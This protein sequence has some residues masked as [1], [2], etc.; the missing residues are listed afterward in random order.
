MGVDA[1]D[2]F[3]VGGEV[4]GVSLVEAWVS[5]VGWDIVGY[6]ARILRGEATNLESD[7]GDMGFTAKA[8]CYGALLDCFGG[9]LYLEDPAL[10][11]AICRLG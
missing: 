10:W 8:Y 4:F 9:V 3:L 2:F 7:K 11:G 5:A 1:D 6:Q